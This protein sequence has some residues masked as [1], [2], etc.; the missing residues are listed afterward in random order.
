MN[1]IKIPDSFI[2]VLFPL[3][4]SR[5]IPQSSLLLPIHQTS[6]WLNL[7]LI[8]WPKNLYIIRPLTLDFPNEKPP[9]TYLWNQ[10]PQPRPV[11]RPCHE[12]ITI[13]S[14]RSPPLLVPR[15]RVR[16]A[17]ISPSTTKL[18]VLRKRFRFFIHASFTFP[19]GRPT[20]HDSLVLIL[21]Q[22]L[23]GLFS[24]PKVLFIES[25]RFLGK[26]PRLWVLPF[27]IAIKSGSSD[28]KFK[29]ISLNKL[30]EVGLSHQKPSDL[31]RKSLLNGSQ[32]RLSV[33]T[34]NHSTNQPTRPE[35]SPTLETA[36]SRI[37]NKWILQWIHCRCPLY[38]VDIVA[39]KFQSSNYD[40][41][42]H[43]IIGQFGGLIR[44]SA[45]WLLVARCGDLS[46]HWTNERLNSRQMTISE[47][48]PSLLMQHFLQL[49]T[50][51]STNSWLVAG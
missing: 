22:L 42:I 21:S 23:T 44:H 49:F 26:F 16:V 19:I 45:N 20:R 28:K 4:K 40:D 43:F 48:P 51:N 39:D 35:Q 15:S 11:T 33:S 3:S 31:C 25:P 36:S 18:L 50:L 41:I 24:T 12:N 30:W 17:A 14:P 34:A 9:F 46:I 8:F 38:F 6:P 27:S 2:L 32:V 10:K 37:Y 7:L 13:R 1:R 29:S 47:L 5:K